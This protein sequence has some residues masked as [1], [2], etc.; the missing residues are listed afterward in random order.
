MIVRRARAYIP[1]A[2]ALLLLQAMAASAAKPSGC[3]RV[4]NVD[5]WDVL[6]IRSKKD[7]RSAAVG[8]IAPDHTGVIRAAGRCHPPSGD[9][10]RMWCPV[11][12][13][14]LPDVKMSGFVKAYFV[15]DAACPAG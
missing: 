11:D 8:A 5:L 13:Y 9:R 4:I 6:Y 10:K 3:Y 14:P 7:H 2:L 1:L 12:Y 15:Q